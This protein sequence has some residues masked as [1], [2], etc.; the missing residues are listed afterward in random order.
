MNFRIEAGLESRYDECGAKVI[1]G[2]IRHLPNGMTFGQR[3][4]SKNAIECDTL[5]DFKDICEILAPDFTICAP[6]PAL[7]EH[8]KR[9]YFQNLFPIDWST[10]PKGVLPYQRDIGNRIVEKM[11]GKAVLAIDMGLGKSLIALLVAWHYREKTLIVTMST[12]VENWQDELK[13]WFNKDACCVVGTKGVVEWN[14]YDFFIISYDSAKENPDV[15]S[16]KWKTVIFDESHAIK[17]ED[18]IRSKALLQ[19]A[20]QARCVLMVSGTP[21]F[22]SPSELYNQLLPVIGLN[23]LGTWEEYMWRY[24]H[25]RR[26]ERTKKFVEEG[27]P[28]FLNELNAFLQTRMIRMTQK[29]A[30]IELPPSTRRIIPF[31]IT[32]EEDIKKQSVVK[33]KMIKAA[34]PELKKQF[35]ME[36]FRMVGESKIPYALEWIR[37]WLAEHPKEEKLVV[38]FF[39]QK[40]CKAIQAALKKD[41]VTFIQISGSVKN[42]MAKLRPIANPEDLSVRVALLSFGSC[43][44]GVTLA[45]GAFHLVNVEFMHTPAIMFQAEKRIDRLGA[46]KPTT[47][48]WLYAQNTHDASVLNTLQYKTNLNSI[49]LDDCTAS[50]EFEKEVEESVSVWTKAGL[51]PNER[52]RVRMDVEPDD[53][54][55]ESFIKRHCVIS[56]EVPET[57]RVVDVPM[58]CGLEADGKYYLLKETVANPEKRFVVAF[59]MAR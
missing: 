21:Q 33:E 12:L 58:D 43:A 13:K 42:R 40:M 54:V 41:G 15:L 50:I 29:E 27:R 6:K 55:N 11:D 51:T 16:R 9:P 22:K 47:C 14:E 45:P 38:F 46:L 52:K 37:T 59:R 26:D 2:V 30:G 35:G 57:V 18:S 7:I 5:A 25:S 19:V 32:N 23:I 39:S 20:M 31:D 53:R 36:L 4:I 48:Y 17:S 3:V 24:C 1:K 49:V 34:T 44:T 56:D 28:R 10:M 8:M